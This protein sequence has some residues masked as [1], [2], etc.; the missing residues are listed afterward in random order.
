M[1]KAYF[2]SF[3]LFTAITLISC[4]SSLYPIS[5]NENDFLFREE[6]LGHWAVKDMQTEFI[7]QKAGN[8]KYNVTVIDKKNKKTDGKDIL[9]SDSSHFSGFLIQ[10]KSQYFFDCT[11][12]TEL[13][14]FDCIGEETK[15]AL[16]PVHLIY[17]IGSISKDQLSIAGIN[18]D[19]LRKFIGKNRNMIRHENPDKDHIL[20]TADPAGLQKKILTNKEAG[21]VFGET[22]ILYRIK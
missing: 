3:L 7:L 9:Y 22:E 5:D 4:V 10:L 21:F 15:S 17:K 18:I 16:L 6:L 12:D 19:S 11:P 8:K 14:Q 20:L 1:R 2:T 13:P